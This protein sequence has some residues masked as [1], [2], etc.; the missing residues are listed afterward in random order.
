MN[1]KPNSQ[2]Q[3]NEVYSK[4]EGNRKSVWREEASP[5]FTSKIDYLKHLGLKTVLDAGCG[6]GRNLVEFAKAGFNV[7]GIDFS[8]S[9]LERCKKNCKNLKVKIIKQNIEN[10]SFK[11]ESF[12]VVICDFVMTHMKNPQKILNEFYRV[13]KSNGP[14]LI[15]FT[16]QKDPHCSQGKKIGKNEY[17]QK[18]FYLRFYNLTQIKKLMKKFSVLA[19]DS[20]YYTDP[21]HGKGY[22][23]KKRH[24]HHSYFVLATK[25]SYN[26]FYS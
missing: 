24:V 18:G 8:E 1:L 14:A 9:A 20:Y 5:F 16:S 21:E 3:W 11:N 15:E 19:V 2:A 25:K 6:D 12:D 22:N 26:R 13:L 23:R 10:T 7:T 4:F 17:L